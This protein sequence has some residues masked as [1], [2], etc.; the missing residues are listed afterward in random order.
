MKASLP[1][2]YVSLSSS[3]SSCTCLR[4]CTPY[5]LK[6]CQ[7]TWS[8]TQ[9]SVISLKLFSRCN[10]LPLPC[11]SKR[12]PFMLLSATVLVRKGGP[13]VFGGFNRR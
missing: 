10:M 9:V 6:C 11:T 8:I 2:S 13:G 7:D 12:M 3:S 1:Y 5:P 4:R